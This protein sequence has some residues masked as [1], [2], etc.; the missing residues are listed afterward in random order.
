MGLYHAV[1]NCE[2]NTLSATTVSNG[3]IQEVYAQS[4]RRREDMIDRAYRLAAKGVGHV[5]EGSFIHLNEWLTRDIVRQHIADFF[6]R[7]E[8][9]DRKALAIEEAKQ[10]KILAQLRQM[11]AEQAI[12]EAKIQREKDNARGLRIWLRTRRIGETLEEIL[13]ASSS[14]ADPKPPGIRITLRGSA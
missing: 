12:R 11:A 3:T 8:L 6:L 1:E 2:C 14:Q 9:M 4:R 13:K 10:R 5:G 7:R